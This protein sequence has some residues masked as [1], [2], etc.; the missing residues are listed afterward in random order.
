MDLGIYRNAIRTVFDRYL[1][2]SK[3]N[4]LDETIAICDAE[5]DNYLMMAVGWQGQKRIHKAFVSLDGCPLA[6][7]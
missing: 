7:R 1:E 5:T 6:G 4:D 2:R 3:S